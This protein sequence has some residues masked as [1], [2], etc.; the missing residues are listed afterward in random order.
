MLRPGWP[1]LSEQVDDF[2]EAVGFC[3]DIGMVRIVNIAVLH[4][5]LLEGSQY[6]P[7]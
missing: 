4:E 7:L 5:S 1:E 6:Y 2:I 3:S